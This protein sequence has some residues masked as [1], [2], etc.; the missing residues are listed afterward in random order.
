MCR[1]YSAEKMVS[2]TGAWGAQAE[3]QRSTSRRS[4]PGLVEHA[5]LRGE[6]TEGALDEVISAMEEMV[7]RDIVSPETGPPSVAPS[8]PEAKQVRPDL[9]LK[10]INYR[11]AVA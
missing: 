8:A 1:A 10:P 3:R 11:R 9:G 5:A 2:R 7:S 6:V 4:M